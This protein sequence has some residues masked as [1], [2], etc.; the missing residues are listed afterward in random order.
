MGCDIH[1]VV[2]TKSK[3]GWYGTDF[4][5]ADSAV[6]DRDYA[7]FAALAGVCGDGPEPNG[8]PDDVSIMTKV[9]LD[10]W[11]D[12][13]HSIGHCSLKHFALMK[14][15]VMEGIGEAARICLEDDMDRI[16]EIL[17]LTSYCDLN[18]YRVVY[19]F[20]N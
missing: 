13:A 12:D 1:V 5:L 4:S 18:Q 8:A 14:I 19:W 15:Q 10:D 9:Y 11:G 16:Y 17:N 2:E 20:D 7:F 3:Y 6:T